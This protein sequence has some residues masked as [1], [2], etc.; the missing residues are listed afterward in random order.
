MQAPFSGIVRVAVLPHPWDKDS[1][2]ILFEHAYAYPRG[3]KVE[4]S[5]DGDDDQMEMRYEWAKDGFGDLLMMALP[6]HM[7]IL[8]L[9]GGDSAVVMAD[10]YQSIKGPMTGIVGS[11]WT[12][13]DN[14]MDIAWTAR[15]PIREAAL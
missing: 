11:I 12:M 15:T 7:D 3:G 14:L 6:H 8:E 13:R 1:E 5:V 4:F 2:D 9:E 10:S